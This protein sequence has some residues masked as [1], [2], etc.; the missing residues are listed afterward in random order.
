MVGHHQSR[1]EKDRQ[2]EKGGKKEK[3]IA[4]LPSRLGTMSQVVG[5]GGEVLPC[6]GRRRGAE[7]IDD[8]AADSNS[9]IRRVLKK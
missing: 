6:R 8:D 2:R 9:Q 7:Q 4:P 3:K 1:L 5:G